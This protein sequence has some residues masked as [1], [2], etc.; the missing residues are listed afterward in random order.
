[1]SSPRFSIVLPTKSRSF[2]VGH[3]IRSV[4]AQT[5]TDLELI[6]A[7]NDDGDATRKAVEAFQD[8]RLRYV[9][10]GGLNMQDNWERGATAATGEYLLLLEDKQMLKC[11]ALEQLLVHIE[12]FKPE[13]LRWTSDSFDDE[14]QPPRIR[15]GKG[16]GSANM[17]SSDVLLAGFVGDFNQ[18]YK[19]TLPLPQLAAVHRRVLDRI[20]A[21]PMRRLFHPVS[22]DIMLGLLL[23][24]ETDEVCVINA[25]LVLYVSSKHSNGRS[26]SRKGQTG[27]QFLKQLAG[28]QGDT[29]DHVPVKCVNVPGGIYNDFQRLR[30]QLGGRLMRHEL[31]WTKYFVETFGAF[32]G[33]A[34]AG[35]DMAPEFQE[36]ERALSTQPSSVQQSVRAAMAARRLSVTS[37]TGRTR[38][39]LGQALGLPRLTRVAKHLIRGRLKQDPEWRFSDPIAYYEWDC[40]QARKVVARAA[41]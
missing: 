41:K 13:V 28:G 23:L 30:G 9:R 16:D 12:R 20:T 21:G 26:V 32:L 33:S 29:Y 19:N 36:W 7:D 10:T 4:L 39:N 37:A 18:G 11:T 35:V 3:A 25:S 8:P 40:Q 38:K 5:C 22:P 14:L 24:N 27:Q 31:N 1:M 17:T 2:L 15:R 34:A 6:V